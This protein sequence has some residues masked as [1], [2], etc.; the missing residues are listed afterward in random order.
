MCRWGQINP[1]QQNTSFSTLVPLINSVNKNDEP[2]SD[3][4][5]RTGY[6]LFHVAVYCPPPSEI[7]LYSFVDH[8]LSTES[9]RTIIQTIVNLLHSKAIS[10]EIS[11]T[12]A[13]QFYNKLVSFFN[14]QY[15]NIL[16]ATSKKAQVKAMLENGLPF[17]GQ[18][19]EEVE[20]CV[21]ESS[22]CKGMQDSLLELG[23]I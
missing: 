9:P 11:L 21:N 4:D 17:F 22:Q 2:P 6:K 23:I 20:K 18:N 7:R 19:Y 1:D 14:L 13:T 5:L 10:D 16:L 8:L 12:L 3:E 15:G